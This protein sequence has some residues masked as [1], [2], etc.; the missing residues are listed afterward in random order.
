MCEAERGVAAVKAAE[1][2]EPLCSG[3]FHDSS[4]YHRNCQQAHLERHSPHLTR[5]LKVEGKLRKGMSMFL[6]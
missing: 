2:S 1:F 5:G 4:C 6:I 3:V